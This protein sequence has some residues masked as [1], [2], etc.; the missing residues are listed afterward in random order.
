LLIAVLVMFT[1]Y[2]TSII[3]MLL[4]LTGYIYFRFIRQGVPLMKVCASVVLACATIGI[5]F[6]DFS[7]IIERFS[8]IGTV[9]DSLADLIK[10]P[11]Y[12]TEWEQDYFSARLYI[13]S[14]Y[15][16]GFVNGGTLQYLIGHGADSWSGLFAKYAHNTF[17]SYLYELGILGALALAYLFLR[18]MG[19]CWSSPL[20]IF[21]LFLFLAFGAFLVMNLGT[22][23]LWQIEGV[24]LFA[25]LNAFAWTLHWEPVLQAPVA[26]TEEPADQ[27]VHGPAGPD[28]N[29]PVGHGAWARGGEG[30]VMQ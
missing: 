1:N 21:G 29:R 25:M 12:Y 20:T 23:P 14:Q 5:G 10:A 3:A 13:W 6:M 26:A 11:A 17:V 7:H 9:M 15:L 16:D 22:M 8:E 2:R 28:V 24:A 4:P 27:D 18:N 30:P 19:R